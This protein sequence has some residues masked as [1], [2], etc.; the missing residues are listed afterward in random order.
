MTIAIPP[1]FTQTRGFLALC[2]IAA[3]ALLWGVY[4]VRV[5]QVTARERS[6]LEER[7]SERERIARELHDTLLQG[8][9]GLTMKMQAVVDKSDMREAS[10]QAMN[11]AM[12]RADA[13]IAEARDRVKDLRSASTPGLRQQLVD[14][15]EHLP[16]E[17][18]AKLRVIE[19]GTPRDLHAIVCEESVRI[20]SEA[21]V[22]ALRHAAASI[23]E[24]EVAY[25]R[26]SLRVNVR[27][28]GQG[29][30]EAV[31]RQGREGHFGLL[32]MRERAKRIRGEIDIW[33]R[34]GSGT[35][36]S[37]TVPARMAYAR[38]P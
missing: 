9:Q 23:V 35:E 24:I 19:H 10:R 21:T 11:D 16:G 6:R 30:E 37:L 31:L 7:L 2:V 5:K 28:D 15:I 3:L 13:L 36:V 1:S 17:Q 27:D 32:G 33:S 38:K 8:V 4:A 29:I 22:N 14:V 34:P 25:E 18:R 12:D 26:R 20:A